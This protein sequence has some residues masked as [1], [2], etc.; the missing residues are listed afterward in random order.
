[1]VFQQY[2]ELRKSFDAL[3]ETADE[4]KEDMLQLKMGINNLE[5]LE[6]QLKKT[7]RSLRPMRRSWKLR[8]THSPLETIILRQSF[9]NSALAASAWK[10]PA[11]TFR[12]KTGARIRHRRLVLLLVLEPWPW[13]LASW[14][15]RC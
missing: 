6:A 1:M 3:H 2:S 15:N 4:H 7:I 13:Y 10:R 9:C 8:M 11:A 14:T 12:L 5:T